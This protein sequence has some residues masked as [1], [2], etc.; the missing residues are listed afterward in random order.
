MKKNERERTEIF[1]EAQVFTYACMQ[2]LIENGTQGSKMGEIA[3][4]ARAI[5]AQAIEQVVTE[6]P[7]LAKRVDELFAELTVTAGK[8]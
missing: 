4:N 5:A 6:H 2:S 1:L 7:K 3:D 8:A